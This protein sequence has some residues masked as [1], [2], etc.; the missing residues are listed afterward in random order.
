MSN[1][2]VAII[3]GAIATVIGGVVLFYVLP[4]QAPGLAP[5]TTSATGPRHLK[6]AMRDGTM[7][8][9]VYSFSIETVRKAAAWA[10]Y[11][12]ALRVVHFDEQSVRTNVKIQVS[13]WPEHTHVGFNFN[14][15]TL[16]VTGVLSRE[17]T[18]EEVSECRRQ[19]KGWSGYCDGFIVVGEVSHGACGEITRAF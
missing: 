19:A 8:G 17:P 10:D 1:W 16:G 7:I 6:C 4:S 15:L 12:V 13:G 18:E 5:P 11:G 2:L 9:R 3:G 14:R